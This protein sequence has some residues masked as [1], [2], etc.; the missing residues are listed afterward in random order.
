[1]IGFKQENI[2]RAE[3]VQDEF[4]HL[5]EIGQ[6]SDIYAGCAQKKTYWI[7]G[8]V[9]DV[10]GLNGNVAYFKAVPRLEESAGEPCLEL[11]FNRLLSRAIAIEIG[12]ASCRERVYVLV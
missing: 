11:K 10:K 8:V 6:K 1:M 9:Q 4:G 7:L 12:R 5:P 3:T 2:G